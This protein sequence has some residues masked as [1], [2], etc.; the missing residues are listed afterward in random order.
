MGTTV[1]AQEARISSR[2]DRDLK[3]ESEA[4]L[5]ELG[6]K[7]S[8]AIS[9]FYTQIV[10]QRGLPLELKIPNEETVSAMQ[11]VMDDTRT[12]DSVD[13]LMADLH[14]EDDAC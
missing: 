14:S 9:M 13:D 12:F 1:M 10:R 8:Q 11:E 5:A 4:I 6:I 7:P 2:I 3:D